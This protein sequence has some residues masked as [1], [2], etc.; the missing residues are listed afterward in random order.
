MGSVE[1]LKEIKRRE[2]A[3]SVSGSKAGVTRFGHQYIT[4]QPDE[5]SE[6]SEVYT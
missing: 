1:E 3:A 4:T 2:S 6:V 5:V